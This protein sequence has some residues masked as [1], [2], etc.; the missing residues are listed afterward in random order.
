[1]FIHSIFTRGAL[2]V[3]GGIILLVGAYYLIKS[4]LKSKTNYGEVLK[5]TFGV[6]LGL[7][8]IIITLW[9]YIE[10]ISIFKYISY[11]IFISTLLCL[12]ENTI[13]YIIN[14]INIVKSGARR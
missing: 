14:Y 6:L 13:V 9:V 3:I 10:K 7:S 4:V 12:C 2:L 8:I 5:H 1:M 11:F